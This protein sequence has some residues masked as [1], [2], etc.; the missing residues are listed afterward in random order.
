MHNINIC[1]VGLSGSENLKGVEG[2]GKSC[3]CSR[4]LAKEY[5]EYR[6]D[7]I[8]NISL[9]DWHSNVV[10]RSHWLYWGQ[11]HKR[12]ELVRS[13]TANNDPLSSSLAHSFNHLEHSASISTSLSAS[14]SSSSSAVDICFSLIEQTEFINDETLSSFNEETT[15]SCTSASNTG[16]GGATSSSS[17]TTGVNNNNNNNNKLLLPYYKRCVRVHF[18]SPH[19]QTYR[20]KEQ[21]SVQDYNYGKFPVDGL[22]VDGFVCVVDTSDVYRRIAFKKQLSQLL[23][24]LNELVKTKKQILLVS[25]KNDLFIQKTISNEK[26]QADLETFL[27]D[28]RKSSKELNKYLH[29]QVVETSADLNVNIDSA[30]YLLALNIINSKHLNKLRN[31]LSLKFSDG[32]EK[33]AQTRAKMLSLYDSLLRYETRWSDEKIPPSSLSTQNNNNNSTTLKSYAKLAADNSTLTS[34]LTTTTTFNYKIKFEQFYSQNLSDVNRLIELYGI[35]SVLNHFNSYMNKLLD[36]HIQQL[37]SVLVKRLP[38][39]L[40]GVFF[41]TKNEKLFYLT[42]AWSKVMQT[43]RAHKQFNAYI[44]V[45]AAATT[46]TTTTTTTLSG[47]VSPMCSTTS[48]ATDARAKQQQQQQQQPWYENEH[49]FMVENQ[50]AI[51]FELFASEQMRIEFESYVKSESELVKLN[52]FKT[53]L[54]NLLKANA[55]RNNIQPGKS[56]DEANVFVMG[57]E[58]YEALSERD[59]VDVYNVFQRKLI[60][61]AKSDY[62]ELLIEQV[63]EFLIKFLK[64]SL[65]VE[66]TPSR[67]SPAAAS[68]MRLD[69]AYLNEIVEYFKADARH[70]KLDRL[71]HER[72][73]VMIK[74]VDFLNGKLKSQSQCLF[75]TYCVEANINEYLLNSLNLKCQLSSYMSFKN[76]LNSR[77]SRHHHHHCPTTMMM[78]EKSS[79]PTTTMDHM[80]KNDSLESFHSYKTTSS[81]SSIKSGSS[82]SK[83]N[84]SQSLNKQSPMKTVNFLNISLI[85]MDQLTA[86]NEDFFAEFDLDQNLNQLKLDYKIYKLNANAYFLNKPQ[87]RTASRNLLNV[88]LKKIKMNSLKNLNKNIQLINGLVLLVDSKTFSSETLKA[89]TKI[90]SLLKNYLSH[91][92][93]QSSILFRTFKIVIFYYVVPERNQDLSM[94]KSYCESNA[95][96]FVKF[97]RSNAVAAPPPILLKDLINVLIDFSLEGADQSNTANTTTTNN[98]SAMTSS[99]NNNESTTTSKL[100]LNASSTTNRSIK[101]K[102][103]KKSIKSKRSSFKSNANSSGKHRPSSTRPSLNI[104]CCMM[105]NNDDKQIECILD[106]IKRQ[107]KIYYIKMDREYS[108]KIVFNVYLNNQIASQTNSNAKFVINQKHRVTLEFVSYHVAFAYLSEKDRLANY[109]GYILSFTS[110]RLASLKCAE[111]FAKNL[112]LNFNHEKQ[113]SDIY[114]TN[115]KICLV[116]VSYGGLCDVF[117]DTT[118]PTQN[119][120][121]EGNRLADELRSKFI[122]ISAKTSSNQYG[123]FSKFFQDC[124]CSNPFASKPTSSLVIAEANSSDTGTGTGD[125]S[126]AKTTRAPYLSEI[127]EDFFNNTIEDLAIESFLLNSLNKQEKMLNSLLSSSRFGV[128]GGGGGNGTIDEEAARSKAPLAKAESIES[129]LFRSKSL[130]KASFKATRRSKLRRLDSLRKSKRMATK[131]TLNRLMNIDESQIV[132]GELLVKRRHLRISR[133]NAKLM[134]SLYS[135]GIRFKYFQYLPTRVL[136]KFARSNTKHNCKCCLLRFERN[137]FKRGKL[138]KLYSNSSAPSFLANQYKNHESNANRRLTDNRNNPNSKSLLLP[139]KRTR[140]SFKDRQQQ[141]LNKFKSFSSRIVRLNLFRTSGGA[142]ELDENLFLLEE[143]SSSSSA[144]SASSFKSSTS[145]SVSF[146]S[147]FSNNSSELNCLDKLRLADKLD[148]H[149]HHQAIKIEASPPPQPP[150]A[151][152]T[153]LSG[154]TPPNETTSEQHAA[155]TGTLGNSKQQRKSN[156]DSALEALTPKNLKKNLIGGSASITSTP[157]LQ[158]RQ[159]SLFPS[160]SSSS[161]SASSSSAAT[162]KRRTLLNDFQL[163]SFVQPATS[164]LRSKHN[165]S[166]LP[167]DTVINSLDSN[168]VCIFIEN[169]KISLT[170]GVP[171]IV[172][173]CLSYIEEFGLDSEGIYRIPGNKQYTDSLLE[174]LLHRQEYLDLNSYNKS[175]INVN[176]VATV[177]KDYFR[178]LKEP[179]IYSSTTAG[180]IKDQQQQQQQELHVLNNSVNSY[181]DEYIEL[182]RNFLFS[183]SVS[184]M[185]ATSSSSSNLTPLLS[186]GAETKSP[187]KEMKSKKTG[188]LAISSPMTFKMPGSNNHNTHRLSTIPKSHMMDTSMDGQQQQQQSS[189][190]MAES[191][192]YLANELTAKQIDELCELI[193]EKFTRLSRVKYLTLKLLFTHLSLVASHANLNSMNSENLAICWWPTLLRPTFIN[194]NETQ[195]L[196]KTLKPLVKFI[197]D[198]ASLIFKN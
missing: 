187:A 175:Q 97:E 182:A 60:K 150:Q 20:R 22:N 46:T 132:V 178:H 184:L 128:G 140:K 48:L 195:L 34:S 7:H 33:Y 77:S 158:Y 111:A 163:L 49:F 144:S 142:N 99:N 165:A 162:S 30:F 124:L 5:D 39:L 122:V 120:V 174:D 74:Y 64:R 113:Q 93:K 24:L 62:L 188:S 143:A 126:V 197:I 149:N 164:L 4:F 177:I 31:T 194:L 96:S 66:A 19:K 90:L 151:K 83:L 129:E 98:N 138:V 36:A 79:S 179:I 109:N 67:A 119:Y 8:S 133:T 136:I 88:L 41:T 186:S 123:L 125:E 173:K 42:S 192:N 13:T 45:D 51:P 87:N 35:T 95:L 25:T 11:C 73:S 141:K 105:C 166:T 168:K 50:L 91:I 104:L 69:E 37:S 196:C 94:L 198:N 148:H 61:K 131:R 102:N 130:K 72:K 116:C 9:S 112:V 71:D 40:N 127:R 32:Y 53:Q 121:L 114:Q 101:R 3:L 107:T 21:L 169:E 181:L 57:R 115:N 193:R 161:S 157:H 100:K 118:E 170:S 145:S 78:M 12:I 59:R 171:I 92:K 23:V 18:E 117:K 17:T 89:L 85:C 63:N 154:A 38:A 159:S 108:N 152:H 1:V 172:E 54:L 81:W 190:F 185:P 52:E 58:C 191:A 68:T 14:A 139:N 134:R 183:A 147:S 82:S 155:T 156:L 103:S 176:I 56:W 16:G 28:V 153:S 47:A 15:S 55:S 86:A 146:S 10:N 180:L 135:Q 6:R 26:N 80:N 65:Y 189:S 106:S 167:S 137:P 160:S 2:V 75:G 76:R 27:V 110:R 44:I 29:G 43:M 70:A 84:D